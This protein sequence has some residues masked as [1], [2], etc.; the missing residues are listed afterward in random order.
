MILMRS[1][2]RDFKG[3]TSCNSITNEFMMKYIVH[4]SS[5]V[6]IMDISRPFNLSIIND[7]VILHWA[8]GISCI[9]HYDTGL[10]FS[11]WK[12]NDGIEHS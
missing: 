11:Q 3:R 7:G 6:Y 5:H 10:A 12:T 1:V 2:G 9:Y 8:I 4:L